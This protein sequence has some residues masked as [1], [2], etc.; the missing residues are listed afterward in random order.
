M[1]FTTELT[2]NGRTYPAAYVKATVARSDATTTVLKLQAWETQALREAGVPSLNWDNDLRV[3]NTD[4]EL[5]SEN[6]ID[7]GYQLL[8]ASGEFPEAT[9]N[10]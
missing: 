8:E 7:Y 10:I 2:I 5:P 9:W 3:M 4:M 6:P 1:A